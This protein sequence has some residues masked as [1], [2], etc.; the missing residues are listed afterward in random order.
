MGRALGGVEKRAICRRPGKNQLD[1]AAGPQ[2]G[3]LG[4]QAEHERGPKQTGPAFLLARSLNT[5]CERR[6]G[7]TVNDVGLVEVPAAFETDI[8]PVV[9]P[10][11][12]VA[13]SLVELITL[14]EVEGVPLKATVMPAA[15]FTP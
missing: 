12:T 8:G 11:G 7:V 6:Y 10:A 3:F 5:E 1:L 2:T 4:L 13:V 14:T 15:K 9:A